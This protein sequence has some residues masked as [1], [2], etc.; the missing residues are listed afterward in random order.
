MIA[1]AEPQLADEA[2]QIYRERRELH[3]IF[4]SMYRK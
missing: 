4:A 1:V 2:R 3:L